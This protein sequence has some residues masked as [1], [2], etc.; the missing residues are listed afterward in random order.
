MLAFWAGG[1][2]PGPITTQ[3]AVPG[4]LAFWMGGASAGSSPVANVGFPGMLAFW[5]GGRGGV[6]YAAPPVAESYSGGFYEVPQVPRRRSVREERERLGIITRE[7][8]QIVMAVARASVVADKTDY[9]AAQQLAQ[10]LE[11]QDIE[12][13]A[14]YVEFMQQERDRILSRD[15][16]RALRIRRRQYEIDEDEREAE[17][18]LM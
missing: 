16:E 5:M 3:A 14:R 8:K 15:I 17:M 4:M 1:A 11:Q 7:V 9:Q 18:L 2:A 10:R 13:R 12:A 6:A